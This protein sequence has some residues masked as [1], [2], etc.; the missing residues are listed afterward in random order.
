LH[1]IN[2][3]HGGISAHCHVVLICQID[4]EGT[5]APS[6]VAMTLRAVSSSSARTRTTARS[7]TSNTY[8]FMSIPF[9]HL[10][11]FINRCGSK[12]CNCRSELAFRL[13]N[14]GAASGG[15]CSKIT[16]SEA[17]LPDS[18][19]SV[20][21]QAHKLAN[22]KTTSMIHQA[23]IILR[24]AFISSLGWALR[25]GI[26]GYRQGQP[27]DRGE[28]KHDPRRRTQIGQIRPE[29]KR[30]SARARVRFVRS[31]DSGADPDRSRRHSRRNARTLSLARSTLDD[32]RR[33]E[34]HHGNRA[35]AAG[36]A[37]ARS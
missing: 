20:H 37:K 24:G 33:W 32:I 23:I 11:R 3:G 9:P 29:C 22:L 18:V 8:S 5:G 34:N 10:D 14:L 26:A 16:S 27:S 35:R 7:F 4:F 28:G 21:P 2:L 6:T 31:Y 12:G 36:A 13:V 19:R 17:R 15:R 25:R 30:A 1:E